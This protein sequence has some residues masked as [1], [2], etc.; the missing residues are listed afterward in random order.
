MLIGHGRTRGGRELSRNTDRPRRPSKVIR[1]IED[2]LAELERI[3]QCL[4]RE[5]TG[6]TE[7]AQLR[8]PLTW[9]RLRIATLRCAE[10]QLVL[11]AVGEETEPTEA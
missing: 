2:R 6:A 1:E 10:R 7:A 9:S 5:M 11:A 4:A 8:R 3:R